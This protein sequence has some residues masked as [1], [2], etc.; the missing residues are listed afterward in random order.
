V[1]NWCSK[2]IHRGI[3]MFTLKGSS[4]IHQK[5]EKFERLYWIFWNT[6]L[7]LRQR[8]YCL[9]ILLV[10]CMLNYTCYLNLGVQ[11]SWP[12]H[13]HFAPI[14]LCF[15]FLRQTFCIRLLHLGRTRPRVIFRIK[16]FIFMILIQIRNIKSARN[17][18]RCR[19]VNNIS[20]IIDLPQ[21]LIRSILTRLQLA[22]LT[23]NRSFLTY[24]IT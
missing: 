21:N 15:K 17:S 19:Q 13:L 18:H 16:S 5:W 1:H 10:T 9:F 4:R 8:L 22:V 2:K 7:F 20:I 14:K 11:Y 6:K 3:L 23:R 24:T 12:F